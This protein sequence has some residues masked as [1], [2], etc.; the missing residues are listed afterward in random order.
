MA[1]L[2]RSWI[3][4]VVV[5][6]TPSAVR[7]QRTTSNDTASAT[8]SV[9]A[10]AAEI[11]EVREALL[12]ARYRRALKQTDALLARP[13]LTASEQNQGLE[14]AA[15]A[16]LALR[17]NAAADQ[18]LSRLYA[19]DPEH[20][21][22]TPDAGPNV[23]AEFD[24]AKNRGTPQVPLEVSHTPPGRLAT[25]APPRIDVVLKGD[26]SAVARVRLAYRQGVIRQFVEVD[27]AM[28]EGVAG[29]DLPLLSGPDD[30]VA[31]Y[32]VEA[33]APSGAVL[34][35]AGSASA[36]LSVSVPGD[37]SK[38]APLGT[39]NTAS[40]SGDSIFTKW[41]FWTAVGVV[42]AGGVTAAVLLTPSNDPPNGSL[43][44]VTLELE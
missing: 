1:L 33:L 37:P 40:A 21:L 29:T 24:R 16:N 42:V 3:I 20:R 22:Q 4:F 30:Y 36:P 25:H 27:L 7:A 28:E 11:A 34:A 9:T 6:L 19:R 32:Y 38:L 8:D 5:A 44:T 43:G 39:S 17:R 18:A 23:H 14:L 26:L 12:Y 2:S 41:W 31:E 10:A 15:I 13:D 35:R